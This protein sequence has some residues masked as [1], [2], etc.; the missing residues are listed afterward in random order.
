MG[1]IYR[2][3]RNGDSLTVQHHR[4][5]DGV[6]DSLGHIFRIE[7]QLENEL[8]QGLR[9]FLVII[10]ELICQYFQLYAI[11]YRVVIIVY[12][13]KTEFFIGHIVDRCPY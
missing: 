1:R 11:G 12:S 6:Y 5:V 7:F 13:D 2:N 10:L 8:C 3:I 9:I 4:L